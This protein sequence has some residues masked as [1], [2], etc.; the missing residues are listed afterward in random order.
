MPLRDSRW[1]D[2]ALEAGLPDCR[3]RERT[4]FWRGRAQWEVVYCANCGV[5]SGGVTPNVP[6]VFFVCDR[7]FD[8]M[9]APPGTIKVDH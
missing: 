1:W 2:K 4:T 8:V 7:C 6:H 9:G 3:S 5:A